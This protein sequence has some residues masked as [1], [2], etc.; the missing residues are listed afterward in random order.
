MLFLSARLVLTEESR[1]FY[2]DD[3]TVEKIAETIPLGRM[4][5]PQDV[6]DACLS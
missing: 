6:A 1:S 2:G 5:S 4:G 3:S